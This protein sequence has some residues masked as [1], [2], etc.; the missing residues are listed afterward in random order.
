MAWR[1]GAAASA[2]QVVV[3]ANFS[4]FATPDADQPHAEYV[5]PNWPAAPSNRRWREV[6]QERWVDEAR[7]GREPLYPWEAKVYA[8]F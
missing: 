2:S 4:D 8:L 1:R 7:A 3:V 6:P 5:V